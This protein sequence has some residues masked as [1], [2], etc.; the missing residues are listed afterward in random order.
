MHEAGTLE[1]A[2][3]V[4]SKPERSEGLKVKL[5]PTSGFCGVCLRVCIIILL[6]ESS[7]LV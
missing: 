2:L 6:F 7:K 5:V 4:T 1:I 3:V